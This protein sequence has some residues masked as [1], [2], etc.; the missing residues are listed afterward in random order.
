M[1]AFVSTL[2]RK[3][4]LIKLADRIRYYF[5]LFKTRKSR[6]S[7]KIKYANVVLPPPYFLYETFSLNYFSYYEDGRDT[8]EWLLN[9]FS[10]YKK[11]ENINI[12]DWGCGPGRIIRH[13]PTL[14]GDSCRCYGSDYNAK[15]VEWC[16]KNIPNVSF[17]TNQLTPPLDYQ[18][19]MFDIIYGISIFTHL[20]EE[21]HYKWFDELMRVLKPGGILFLTLQ[22]A[23]FKEKLTASEIS[24]YNAG[25][26][27]VR[28]N[29][30][31][32]HRTYGAF[33]P[34]EFVYKLVGN[35]NVLKHDSGS[36]SK[37]KPEQDVWIIQ[38]RFE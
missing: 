9:Y 6:K 35:N 1:K 23:V 32:G 2:I 22:G 4:G 11:L 19:G 21:M 16:S 7:F 13:L 20:S 25:K 29:T 17:S 12:L 31:E 34:D 8:A 5:H 3:F 38:K 36:K 27:V 24:Q 26:L 14:I 30:L 33:Q 15:Y 28:A 10:E 18:S 37:G